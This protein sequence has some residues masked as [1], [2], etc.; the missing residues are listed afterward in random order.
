MVIYG[1]SRILLL[2]HR[3]FILF[4]PFSHCFVR[5]FLSGYEDLMSFIRIGFLRICYYRHHHHHHILRQDRLSNTHALICSTRVIPHYQFPQH[6]LHR[7]HRS[8]IFFW[9]ILEA[10]FTL[11]V[12]FLD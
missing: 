12:S 3:I 7:H 2:L 11:C 5:L 9:V 1:R 6:S 8:S 10:A 4:F